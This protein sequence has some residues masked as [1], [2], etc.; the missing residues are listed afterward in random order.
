MGRSIEVRKEQITKAWCVLGDFNSI[1]TIEERKSLNTNVDYSREIRWFGSFIEKTEL[2]DIPMIERKFTWYKPNG[3][4][5]GRLDR[6]LVS[7]EWIDKW[8]DSKQYDLSSSMSDHCVLV[9]KDNY[10]DWG[11]K[12]LRFLDIWQRD[13]IFKDL[14]RSR[15][16]SCE[17]VGCLSLKKI[18]KN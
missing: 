10:I 11:P 14:I 17:M 18:L 2:L 13:C 9:L 8:P 3:T 7:I 15:S 16:K 4:I 1:R 12:P 5:K 6:I